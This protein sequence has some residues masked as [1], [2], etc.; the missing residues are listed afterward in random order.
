[1]QQQKIKKK[2]KAK[3]KVLGF[4]LYLRNDTWYAGK[5]IANKLRW[6]YVGKDKSIAE[7]KIKAWCS[8]NGIVVETLAKPVFSDIQERLQYIETSL[9]KLNTHEKILETLTE[10]QQKNTELLEMIYTLVKE[11]SELKA[12][13]Q[14]VTNS[15]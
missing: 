8:K 2:T 4:S 15:T 10:S 6:V 3:E 7:E 13:L 11:N 12:K 1:M 5:R 14:K 9:E